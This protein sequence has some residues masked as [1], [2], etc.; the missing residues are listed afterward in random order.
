[1]PRPEFARLLQEVRRISREIAAPAAAD[2][3]A[4]ARFPR[5][6]VD[7][8]RAARVLSAP[9]PQRLGG[10]GLGLAET[11]QLC[12]ALAQGCA[13]SGM[14]L[15]MHAS[16][17]ACVARHAAGSPVL[18]ALLRELA[19]EQRLYASMTS[20]A[21]TFG[22]TRASVCAIEPADDPARFTLAKDA[23]TGSYCAHADAILVTA[24]RHAQAAPGDQVL[25]FLR[26]TDATL[27]QVG[28]W[29]TL[30]MRGTCSPGFRLEAA[31]PRAQ[32][33]PADYADISA[34]TMV[35]W[36]HVLW[37]AVWTGIAADAHA[38]AAAFVRGQARR[39]PG[40]LPPAALRLAGLTTALQAMRHHWQSVA[41]E[42]DALPLPATAAA[43]P[44]GA[45]VAAADAPHPLARIAWSLKFN[46]LK[47]A[48]A[49]RAPEIVHGALQ[50]VGI[51]GYKNDTPFSL[52]RHY[53]DA[54]SAALMISNDR[55]AAQSA[56]LLLVFKDDQE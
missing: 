9:V 38:R 55:I 34:L 2:V 43:P 20:E 18:E 39:D 56:R 8:L 53:R 51:L 35:P 48:A 45:A 3:D 4:Q 52:G 22:D 5:E 14:V 16:Q 44:P 19:S 6:A 36:S 40:S 33:L 17:V 50:I 26:A 25:A 30:G 10:A 47:T 37:A 31:A 12:Q 11:G 13:S 28:S 54:L 41:A 29:D 46:S 15:A 7:A 32:I 23:T 27:R 21:G 24:R 49:E 42:V 1:M